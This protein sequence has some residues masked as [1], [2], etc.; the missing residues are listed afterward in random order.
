MNHSLGTKVWERQIQRYSDLEY[1]QTA[2]PPS[3][4][5]AE[6]ANR[7]NALPMTH[8]SLGAKVWERQIQRYSDLELESLKVWERQTLRYW[9]RARAGSGPFPRD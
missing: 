8:H 6:P 4:Q 7:R 2:E 1:R 3:S 5:T 9:T